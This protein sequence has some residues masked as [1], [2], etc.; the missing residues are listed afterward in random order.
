L[1]GVGE[2]GE[3]LLHPG[4]GFVFLAT[5]Q[6]GSVGVGLAAGLV[7]VLP[8]ALNIPPKGRVFDVPGDHFEDQGMAFKI[9]G[10]VAEAIG[11]CFRLG[12][13]AILPKQGQA[14]FLP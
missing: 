8:I 9:I 4:S 10:H 2:L 14:L 6:L 3:G 11:V 5:A 12:S 7:I 13:Q 1:G